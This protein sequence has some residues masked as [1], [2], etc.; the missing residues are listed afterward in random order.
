M[1]ETATQ[2]APAQTP[3]APAGGELGLTASAARRIL[4]VAE[5]EGNPALGLRISV[6]GGGCSGFQY[7]FTL[8]ADETAD[9]VVITRDGARLLVD[10][11]SLDFLRGSE[12][13]FVEDLSG[14]GFR[15]NNPLATSSC[16]CGN[17]FAV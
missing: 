4:K 13:D 9:D 5:S 15:I 1:T 14:A 7:S 11:V 6:S 2:T 16:G 10:T 8:D 3:S 12:L 17:S